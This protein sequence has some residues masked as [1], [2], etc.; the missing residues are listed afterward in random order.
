MDI[1]NIYLL[2]EKKNNGRTA[3]Y[4]NNNLVYFIVLTCK[5][6]RCAKNT[7][8]YET[9]NSY[10]FR[11]RWNEN[12]YRPGTIASFAAALFLPILSLNAA[13]CVRKKQRGTV[14]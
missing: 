7:I 11:R 13:L 14:L 6:I 12:R 5:H 1:L 4:E 3:K 9:K 8:V 10:E 2:C